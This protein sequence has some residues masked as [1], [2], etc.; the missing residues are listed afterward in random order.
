MGKNIKFKPFIMKMYVD[1][2]GRHMS[3]TSA[4]PDVMKQAKVKEE[5]QV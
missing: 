2:G 3:I 1:D 4:E 5:L